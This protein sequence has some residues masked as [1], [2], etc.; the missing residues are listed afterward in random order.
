MSMPIQEM[1]DAVDRFWD[2]TVS[3]GKPLSAEE[4]ENAYYDSIFPC[5]I[6][7]AVVDEYDITGETWPAVLVDTLKHLRDK[8]K[9]LPQSPATEGMLKSTNLRIR[10]TE[11]ILAG[12]KDELRALCDEILTVYRK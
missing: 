1:R 8:L 4:I 5:G 11:L 2:A 7:H 10:K 6:L 3:P 9:E 12:K